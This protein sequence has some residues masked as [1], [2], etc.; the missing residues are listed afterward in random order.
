MRFSLW[1]V[2]MSLLFLLPA[3]SGKGEVSPAQEEATKKDHAALQGEWEIVSA[4]SN[5][6]PPP[7]GFLNQAKLTFSGDK[8][9]LMGKESRFELDASKT[10]R[11]I[12]F[13]LGKSRQWGIY[14]LDGD[15]LKLCVC[16]KPPEDRPKEFKTKPR[17]DHTLFVMKRKK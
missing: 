8:A 12:D 14:E 1:S 9:T 2:V 10:P 5:G 6:E 16:A 13:I 17:T 3:C 15:S 11:Q 4:E 7:P